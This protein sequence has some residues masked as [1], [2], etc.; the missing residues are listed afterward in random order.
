MKK[1]YSQYSREELEEQVKKLQEEKALFVQQIENYKILVD[2][3][4]R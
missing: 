3:L 4:K 1:E 2:V